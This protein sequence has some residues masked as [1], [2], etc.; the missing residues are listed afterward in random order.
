MT[1]VPRLLWHHFWNVDPAQLRVPT[2]EQFVSRGLLGND[3]IAWAWAARNLSTDALTS[4]R[5]ARGIDAPTI[6]LI[7]N[8]VASR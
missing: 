6:A 3:P 5:T 4:A 7:D 1:R 2:D 8:L